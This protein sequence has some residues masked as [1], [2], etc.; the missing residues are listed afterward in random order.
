MDNA[1]RVGCNQ[2]IDDLN[3]PL[4]Y[5]IRLERLVGE[6][7]AE[8]LSL[9]QLHDD[10]WAAFVLADIMDGANVRMIQGGGGAGL[11]P[12]PIEGLLVLGVLLRQ[13][14]QRDMATEASIFGFVDYTHTARA[15][16]FEDSV[17]VDNLAKDACSRHRSF[18]G[19]YT[20]SMNA[21]RPPRSDG[22]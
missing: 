9:Q 15:E 1:L 12:E 16:L 18:S 7:I 13:E 6:A 5:L 3:S 21:Y 8:R 14:L 10:V 22:C 20:Q 4:Q 17:V 2:R 11:T 19:V